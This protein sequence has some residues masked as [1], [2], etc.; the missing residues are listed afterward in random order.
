MAARLRRRSH[1]D[2]GCQH[3]V[4]RNVLFTTLRATRILTL[5]AKAYA[6]GFGPED[7]HQPSRRQTTDFRRV[8]HQLLQAPFEV[9]TAKQNQK[10]HNYDCVIVNESVQEG[11]NV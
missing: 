3:C 10:L 2:T 5:Q 8:L 1:R 4:E 9:L 7:H 6:A 11:L